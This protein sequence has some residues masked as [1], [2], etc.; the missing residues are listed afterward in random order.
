ML[1]CRQN[2][3][4]TCP[5]AWRSRGLPRS[6]VSLLEMM[7]VV[8][9]LSVVAAISYPGFRRSL[10]RNELTTAARQLQQDLQRARV[11]AMEG[12][13]VWIFAPSLESNAFFLGP[14]EEFRAE[15]QEAG[16]DSS[17]LPEDS[18]NLPILTPQSEGQQ[19]LPPGVRFVPVHDPSEPQTDWR[20]VNDSLTGGNSGL[21]TAKETLETEGQTRGVLFYPNGRMK[22]RQLALV[23]DDGYRITILIQGLSGR[24]KLSPVTRENPEPDHRG[25]LIPQEPL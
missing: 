5:R 25:A 21:A 20:A 2:D 10:T 1:N 12:G 13:R 8:A 14:L 4:L 16:L 23:N 24:I 15:D 22:S 3:R 6:G 11:S 17:Q 9:L 19:Q 18:V 7:V